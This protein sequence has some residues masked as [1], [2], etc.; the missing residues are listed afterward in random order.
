MSMEVHPLKLC[1]IFDAPYWFCIPSYQR[2]Y[3]WGKDEILDLLDDINDARINAHGDEN[4]EYFLGAIVLRRRSTLINDGVTTPRYSDEYEV[5]DGQQRLTTLFITLTILSKL[6]QNKDYSYTLYNMVHQKAIGLKRIPEIIRIKY[7]RDDANDRIKQILSEAYDANRVDEYPTR[8]IEDIS[9][10][11]I[12]NAFNIIKSYFQDREKFRD[13]NASLAA[14]STFLCSNTVIIDVSANTQTEAFRLFSILNNR[15]MPLNSADIIKAENIGE[16]RPEEKRAR[17]QDWERIENGLKDDDIDSFL[18]FIRTIYL[19]AKQQDSLLDEFDKKIY[20]N[21]YPEEPLLHR[22]TETIDVL[23]TYYDIYDTI[24]MCNGIDEV[25]GRYS[26]QYKQL[27]HIMKRSIRSKD[28]IPPLMYF[29]KE[30]ILDS[31]ID[32]FAQMMDFIHK[33]EYKFVGDWICGEKPT[34]RRNAMYAILKKIEDIKTSGKSPQ[35]IIEDSELFYV[36]EKKLRN[37]LNDDIYGEDYAT[38]VLL[39][40]EYLHDNANFTEYKKISIEHVLPQTV[41]PKSQWNTDF[42]EE[43]IKYWKHRLANLLLLNPIRNQEFKNADYNRKREIYFGVRRDRDRH[44]GVG[45]FLITYDTL[46]NA[47]KWTPEV[48]TKR[49]DQLVNFFIENRPISIDDIRQ[50]V[51]VE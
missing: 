41:A 17:T 33:L 34:A 43:Q 45:R 37:V 16:L 22:G 9:A 31:N 21:N 5:L 23:R 50:S 28:W 2:P 35:E 25:A 12:V 24:V 29:Y 10:K 44:V 18:Q 36:D 39:K 51:K 7:E 47:D 46:D 27:V 14:F 3:R 19:K 40:L 48:L 4:A 38:Y 1:K 26:T 8:N 15:G 32:A 11:N 30:F 42:A 6:I 13:V 20:K 49:Q